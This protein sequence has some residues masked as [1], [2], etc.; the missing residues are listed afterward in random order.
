[1]RTVTC[2]GVL[3]STPASGSSLTTLTMAGPCPPSLGWSCWTA[4][5]A[6]L[7]GPTASLWGS[8][9]LVLVPQDVPLLASPLWWCQNRSHTHPLKHSVTS[10][11]GKN[12]CV[13]HALP[14][15]GAWPVHPSELSWSLE[16][17]QYQAQNAVLFLHCY[18]KNTIKPH[19]KPDSLWGLIQGQ[20]Y[21]V[22]H[23][24]RSLDYWSFCQLQVFCYPRIRAK[25]TR[26][27]SCPQTLRLGLKLLW[28][29]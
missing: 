18:Q 6:S 4:T 23:P 8:S 22:M 17:S 28:H 15:C 14:L 3:H 16:R 10:V 11:F 21:L 12:C 25:S 1:M 9:S 20:Q 5:T 2:Q 27:K 13:F 24:G 26:G 29:R 7:W 19:P